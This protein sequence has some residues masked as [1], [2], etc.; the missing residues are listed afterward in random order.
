MDSIVK[1]E[2]ILLFTHWHLYQVI[3]IQNKICFEFCED[4]PEHSN[5]ECNIE[6]DNHQLEDLESVAD[7]KNLFYIIV[8]NLPIIGQL[9]VVLNYVEQ[10]LHEQGLYEAHQLRHIEQF[11]SFVEAYHLED[12]EQVLSLPL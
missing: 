3:D 11:E 5:Q 1:D 12:E 6:N 8:A 9:L 2:G 4:P 10:I 7:Y